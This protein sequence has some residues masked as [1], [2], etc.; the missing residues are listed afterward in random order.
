MAEIEAIDPRI[1]VV[2]ERYDEPHELRSARGKPGAPD[3]RDRAPELTDAQRAAFERV[4][5]A[6]VIDLPYDVGKLAPRLRWVQAVGAGT[7]QLQSAGIVEAGITLTSNAGSNS[8]SIGE[9]VIGRILQHWKR[10]PEI[11]AAQGRHEWNQTLYGRELT[12]S[13]LGLIGLGHINAVVANRAK[14]FGM[15]VLATRRSATPGA[16]APDVDEVLP[17]S[18][19]ATMLGRADAVVA[20]VPETPETIGLMDAAAFAA[21]QAGAFFCNV[22][23]GSLVD[24]AA[25]IAALQSGQVGAAAL[26]VASQRTASGRRPAVGRAEPLPLSPRVDV[27]G[28][29]VPEPA[30]HV[31]REPRTLPRGRGAREPGRSRSRVLT[32]AGSD[33]SGTRMTVEPRSWRIA[34]AVPLAVQDWG[35]DGAPVLLAHPTGFHGTVW[36]PIATRLVAAGRHVFSFDFRG[37]GESDPS[38]SG[39]DVGRVRRG[40]ARRRRR[41]RPRRRAGVAA[42]RALE[43]RRRVPSRRGRRARHLPVHLGVRADRHPGR[44]GPPRRGRPARARRARAGATTWESRDAA[45]AAFSSRPPLD[46]L[47]ADALRAYVER[48]F[49]D[50]D[51]AAGG[52]DADGAGVELVCRP[53]DEAEMYALRAAHDAWRLL[54]MVRCPVHVVCGDATDAMTPHLC[55][56]VVGRLPDAILEVMPGL[57]HFGPLQDPDARGAVDA[58]VRAPDVDALPA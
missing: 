41:A 26:D 16:T 40:R 38:P 36:R 32:A 6:V 42:R 55:E 51:T 28:L 29:A 57:G 22:G 2:V 58:R 43:G 46:V 34:A 9:F 35:G 45:L 33:G 5:V 18:E 47:D 48:G 20:A 17:T 21:M 3:L 39:Y 24:E 8:V 37:H 12:G 10:Y 4:D 56:R 50:V 27:A 52:G 25:L 14:A 1:E 13:T 54:P 49:R 31:P 44:A 23:R 7:G 53:D 11:E 19:L 30:P 15:E